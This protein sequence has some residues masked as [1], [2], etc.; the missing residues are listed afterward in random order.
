MGRCRTITGKEQAGYWGARAAGSPC[1]PGDAVEALTCLTPGQRQLVDL[2]YLQ[3]HTQAEAATLLGIRQST[4]CSGLA[5]AREKAAKFL[6]GRAD[7]RR[8]L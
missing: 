6:K 2:V 1:R 4:V 5:A 8:R 3:G 7:E